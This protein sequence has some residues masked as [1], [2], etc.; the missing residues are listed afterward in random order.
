MKAT[1]DNFGFKFNKN[2]VMSGANRTETV[3]NH[4]ENE[5]LDDQ[6]V[7]SM[8]ANGNLQKVLQKLTIDDFPE[9]SVE[10]KSNIAKALRALKSGSKR[11]SRGSIASN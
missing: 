4:S 1:E 10:S 5:E 2:Q 7:E 3:E 6:Q 8:E 9:M 11:K